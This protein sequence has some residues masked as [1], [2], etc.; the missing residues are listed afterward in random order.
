[1]PKH[2]KDG[3][4]IIIGRNILAKLND[5]LNAFTD[6]IVDILNPIYLYQN[7]ND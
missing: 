3:D 7:I 4:T 1:M 5:G 6:P 2:L